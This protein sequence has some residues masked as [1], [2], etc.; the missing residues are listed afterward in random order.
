MLTQFQKYDLHLIMINANFDLNVREREEVFFG[1]R[2][3]N[4]ES[5]RGSFEK[6]NVG[7][8]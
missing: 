7:Y 4:S 6:K 3:L 5:S 8:F 2:I 1:V